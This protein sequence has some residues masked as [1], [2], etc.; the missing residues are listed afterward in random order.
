MNTNTSSS[1]DKN[2]R[3]EAHPGQASPQLLENAPTERKLGLARSGGGFRASLFHLGALKRLAELDS[4]RY[5]SV[6]STVSGGSILG[7]LYL[8]HLKL[9]LQRAIGPLCRDDYVGIVDDMD[10]DL[11]RAV[12]CNLRTRLLLNPP[13]NLA[14]VC[15]GR[16]LGRR[17]AWL[18][19]RVLYRPIIERLVSAQDDWAEKG[20]STGRGEDFSSSRPDGDRPG[21]R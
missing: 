19:T 14:G 7:A 5:L 2:Y 11:R 17:M 18:Y 20:S 9:C 3:D 6:T 4:L 10:V 21:G 1:Y 13:D 15:L 8:L 12:Q 16:S